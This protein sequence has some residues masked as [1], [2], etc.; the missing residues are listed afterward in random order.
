MRA[1]VATTMRIVLLGAPGSGK[2]TQSQRLVEQAGVP[3]ISTG[4]LLRAAVARG[5]ELGRKAKE[6]MDSGR[7]VED[8]MYSERYGDSSYYEVATK[9]TDYAAQKGIPAATLA[10][11]W[12]MTQPAVTS[13]I[14]GARNVGQ[15]EQSLAAADLGMTPEWRAEISALS[16][17]PPLATDRSEEQK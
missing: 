1:F 8:K 12:V 2:G 15:L 3:Q 5:S 11:A 17:E 4:D 10:V 7:L 13:A 6:A 9:F 14:M 16:P